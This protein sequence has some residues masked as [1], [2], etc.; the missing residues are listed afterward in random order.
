[1]R[2]TVPE[3]TLSPQASRVIRAGSPGSTSATSTSSM[4]AETK[5]QSLAMRSTTGGVGMPGGDGVTYSLSSPLISATTPSKGATRRVLFRFASAT[6]TRLAAT[7]AEERAATQSAS[8]AS[9][10]V[11]S[12]SS[13]SSDAAPLPRSRAVRSAS[14]RATSAFRHAAL[15]F[16][17]LALRSLLASSTSAFTSSFQSSTSNCPALTLSPSRIPM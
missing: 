10:S 7:S 4:G 5:K 1:M 16:A 2:R 17:S 15:A 3:N 6:S 13:W 11:S 8:D 12:L 9:A 14:R